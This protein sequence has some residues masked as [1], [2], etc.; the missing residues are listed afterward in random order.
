MLG[1]HD[2]RLRAN[3]HASVIV[4]AYF[5][6]LPCLE[7]VISLTENPFCFFFFLN[8][9]NRYENRRKYLKRYYFIYCR[10]GGTLALKS[11][12]LACMI[13]TLHH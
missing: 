11:V 10:Y 7:I 8:L 12:R 5:Q 2:E 3:L 9:S 13:F 1:V 6:S 4:M